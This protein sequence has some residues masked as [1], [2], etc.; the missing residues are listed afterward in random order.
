[1]PEFG[2][3]EG[4]MTVALGSVAYELETT[5]R[6]R[7]K[8]YSYT[9][10]ERDAALTSSVASICF[11][12]SGDD[13][14]KELLGGV[15]ETGFSSDELTHFFEDGHDETLRDWQVGEAFAEAYL[16][17]HLDCLFPWPDG[18]DVRKPK[19]SLP[20]ADLVGFQ[21]RGTGARFAFGEVKT[22][23]EEAYPPK[24]VRYGNHALNTQ[25]TDLRDKKTIRKK[26]M[27]YLGH[28]AQGATWQGE[29]KNA[30]VRYIRSEGRDVA[31]LGVL[32]RDVAPNSEDLQGTLDNL[33]DGFPDEMTA[34]L[35]G[36]YMPVDSIANFANSV[37]AAK[38]GRS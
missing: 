5:V 21:G 27:K 17:T 25:L 10:E 31:L 22:S 4:G 38:E 12:E 18:R 6:I 37:A 33:V 30:S 32:V 8:A 11:D 7:A 28:R 29:Y 1:M 2:P 13:E 20:G 26:L 9:D 19:S 23:G 24:V 16:G 3:R 15:D 35:L 36:L 14:L 34:E